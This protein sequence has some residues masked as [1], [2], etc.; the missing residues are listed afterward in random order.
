MKNI[1]FKE[2][3][4]MSCWT[5]KTSYFKLLAKG[6]NLISKVILLVFLKKTMRHARQTNFLKK[7]MRHARNKCAP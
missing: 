5:T 2:L 6:L 4:Q 3:V 1:D 7:I